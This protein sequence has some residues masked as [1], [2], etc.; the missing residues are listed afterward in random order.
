MSQP[1]ASQ[2]VDLSPAVETLDQGAEP[3][4]VAAATRRRLGAALV[5]ALV[6]LA[7]G[8]TVD[9]WEQGREFSALM[10]AAGTAQSEAAAADARVAS[11]IAYV[12]PAQGSPDVPA[13]VRADLQGM[14]TTAAQ[15]AARTLRA[16]AAS[17]EAVPVHRWHTALLAARTAYAQQLLARAA[18][19]D[20]LARHDP[21]LPG[22]SELTGAT[23]LA[24][25]R[26]AFAA[27]AT[28]SQGRA[29]VLAVLAGP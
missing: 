7:L 27:A 28:S 12:D 8:W 29:Q 16:E 20:A 23:S 4:A 15:Q 26:A 21:V 5:A 18:V 25:V 1:T 24:P 9:R 11:M 3:S 13:E 14:V 22:G 6:L 2:P 17:V 10:R 19:L